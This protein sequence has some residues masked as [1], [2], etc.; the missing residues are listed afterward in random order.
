MKR[1]RILLLILFTCLAISAWARAPKIITFD[2]PGAG[3]GAGQ[4][5]FPYGISATGEIIGWYVDA[6]S[7]NHGLLRAPN[8]H[9]LSL[10]HI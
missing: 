8:G 5:T 9:F 1:I 10:I 3:T 2:V 6:N 4:G 7:V